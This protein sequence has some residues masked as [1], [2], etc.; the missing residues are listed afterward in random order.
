MDNLKKYAGLLNEVAPEGEFLAYINNDEEKM[1][2]KAG[3]KGVLT[4]SGIRSYRGEGGPDRLGIANRVRSPP[5]F[6]SC[7]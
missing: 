3:G 7:P 4:E 2:R 1:L 5:I 6:F